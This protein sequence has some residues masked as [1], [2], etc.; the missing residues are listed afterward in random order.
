VLRPVVALPGDLADARDGSAVPPLWLRRAPE[1]NW[2]EYLADAGALYVQYNQVR[3]GQEES[4]AAFFD[5][6]SAL[7]DREA[8]ARLILDIRLNWGGNMSLNRPLVHH[9]IRSDRV[10][11]WG[12]LFVI[13]GR[14]TFSAAMNLAVD[15]ERHSRALFVGEPTGARPNHYGETVEIVL[16]H[17]GLRC[18]ASALWWQYSQPGDDRPWIAPDIA[19]PL[20]SDDYVANRDPALDAA[21]G[22]EPQAA[23]GAD[24]RHAP[25]HLARCPR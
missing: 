10:N 6:V 11:Q 4:V 3:D 1:H 2:C 8:V 19:A 25:D 21:L 5:R 22:Y 9:L 14:C 12:K 18:T 15:L 7:V 16:P 24:D 17:S 23:H 20:W 13:I